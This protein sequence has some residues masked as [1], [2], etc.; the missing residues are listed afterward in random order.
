MKILDLSFVKADMW[1]Y[2]VLVQN[3]K[4][5]KWQKDDNSYW[6]RI[7]QIYYILNKIRHQVNYS[8]IA[9]LS[10]ELPNRGLL[11]MAIYTRN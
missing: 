3:Y 4:L 9:I 10:S 11:I 5:K 1:E 6:Q 7:Q 2:W 8:V